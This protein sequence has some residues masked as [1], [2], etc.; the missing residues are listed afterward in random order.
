MKK[1]ALALLLL[2][3]V[4]AYLLY[5]PVPIEPVAWTPPPAPS[6]EQGPYAYNEKLKGIEKLA[7][8]VGKGPE[9]VAV[10]AAG[11]IYAGFDDGRVAR[12]NRDGSGYTLL[13]QTGGRPLGLTFG[14]NG[15]V[16]VADAVKGLLLVGGPE[17]EQTLSV[18]AEGVPYGFIDDA[19]NTR[20]DKNLYFTDASTRFGIHEVMA[21]AMEHGATGRVMRHNV[22]TNETTVLMKGLHFPNGVAVGPD[23]AYILVNET[24]EYR[25]WR[26]WLKGEKAGQSEVFAENLPG[27]PDNISFNGRDRFWVAIYAPRT[28]DLDQLLPKPDLRKIV[29][30]LPSFVQPKPAMHA[31]VLG[32]DLDGKLV[33]NLQYKGDDVYAPITSAEEFNGWLYFGSLSYPAL[34]RIKL[35]DI[36]G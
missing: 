3:A 25:I 22:E 1:I 18:D 20:M 31:F 24:F 15:G 11:R 8:G 33:A 6:L 29:F 28:R 34:G 7:Q 32:F 21:D 16:V 10:D 2:A 9:G 17:G 5:W 30:R 35:T 23:D 27:F 36:G 12:F 26:H 14:P 4:A 13:A 19:D